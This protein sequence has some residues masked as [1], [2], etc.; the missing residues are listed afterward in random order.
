MVRLQ[1]SVHRGQLGVD[2]RRCRFG[3][4]I[5]PAVL[6][7]FEMPE[8]WFPDG[9]MLPSADIVSRISIASQKAL[10][11]AVDKRKGRGVPLRALLREGDPRSAI[12]AAAAELGA[13]VIVMGTHG[14][15]G[16][17]HLLLG[18]VAERVVRSAPI[19]VLTVNAGDK[20]S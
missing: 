11:E 10:D 17:K 4:L 15:R 20:T 9:V 5:S 2:V 13:E 12:L 19:P 7:A 1:S 14:R 16:I 18:S 6:H 3:H 8:V